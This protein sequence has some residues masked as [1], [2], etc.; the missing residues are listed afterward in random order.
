MPG[1]HSGR[2][3][4][5]GNGRLARATVEVD[6]TGCK[7]SGGIVDLGSGRLALAVQPVSLSSGVHPSGDIVD[8][9]DDTLA[10]AAVPM[11]ITTAH[12]SGVMVDLGSGKLATAVVT[13]GGTLATGQ[14]AQQIVRLD[15]DGA[16]VGASAS[17]P[18]TL[19]AALAY[20]YEGDSGVSS[21]SL[22]RIP[23]T[24]AGVNGVPTLASNSTLQV[25]NQTCTWAGWF[26]VDN[27]T[28]T[29]TLISKNATGANEWDFFVSN[30]TGV[31]GIISIFAAAPNFHVTATGTGVTAK[32]PF[33]AA[34]G[35][36]GSQQWIRLNGNARVNTAHNTTTH[37][38]SA[39]AAALKFGVND[40]TTEPMTGAVGN[41]GYWRGKSLSDAELNSLYNSGAGVDYSALSGLGLTT[42]LVSYWRMKERDGS[43]T[44]SHGTNHI[45]STT[46]C[47]TINA[48]GI[49][50]VAATDGASVSQWND[51]SANNRH[52]EAITA[53]LN[54]AQDYRPMY[55]ATGLNNLPTLRFHGR[56]QTLRKAF[57]QAQ[58]V[59]IFALVKLH[60]W[61]TN[62]VILDGNTEDVMALKGSST[63][64]IFGMTVS[65][66]GPTL[67]IPIKRWTMVEA[68]F[69]GANSFIRVNGGSKISAS[70]GTTTTGGLWLALDGGNDLA[71]DYSK[72]PDIEYAEIF[73]ANA[74]QTDAVSAGLRRYLTDKWGLGLEASAAP[75]WNPD[76]LFVMDGSS[77]NAGFA[78]GVG[79][80]ISNY[81]LTTL[82]ATWDFI[83]L[84]YGGKTQANCRAEF[85][86]RGSWA[87]NGSRSKNVWCTFTPGDQLIDAA[88]QTAQQ[89]WDS[90][91]L[92][93]AELRAAGWK[94]VAC[95]PTPFLSAIGGAGYEA[96]VASFRTIALA[97][98]DK[99]DALVDILSEPDIG[100]FVGGETPD[101][102]SLWRDSDRVHWSF[103][104]AEKLAALYATAI[105]SV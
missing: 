49:V 67:G 35:F 72:H 98:A 58:P 19:D 38:L 46:R 83:D 85:A 1:V 10:I 40:A 64:Q 3:I 76:K 28:T 61:N 16:M 84:T 80:N 100:V 17:A 24:P 74:V 86:A 48:L 91:A 60:N 71:S 5:Y 79:R 88:S 25:T 34:W 90:Y 26:M 78:A 42:N 96:R 7:H 54:H 21:A 53:S 99:Y 33:F 8:L 44:D 15:T 94:V 51:Q 6:G 93:L 56:E 31:L 70:T 82:G 13:I 55:N 105:A 65:T 27:L 2:L 41:V 50:S 89:A 75:V 63:P 81:T 52:L 95:T 45:T 103:R 92:H 68:V 66:A 102:N 101:T 14:T 77:I 47:Q 20:H 69:D 97:N 87:F 62:A 29:M 73:A 32:V 37:A 11:D 39:T 36:D 18:S 4:D 30:T 104:G 23:G 57:T 59:H 12:H 9:T 43:L 22:K